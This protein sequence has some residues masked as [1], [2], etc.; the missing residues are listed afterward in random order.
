MGIGRSQGA[1]AVQIDDSFGSQLQHS[2]FHH[3]QSVR[4]RT[5]HGRGPGGAYLFR[6]DLSGVELQLDW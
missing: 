3:R 6:A 5:A 2:S 1:R 4:L